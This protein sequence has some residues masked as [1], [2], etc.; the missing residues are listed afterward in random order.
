MSQ[1]N[2][3]THTFQKVLT[4]EQSKY[5]YTVNG[6]YVPNAKKKTKKFYSIASKSILKKECSGK[7]KKKKTFHMK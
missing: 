2:L 6:I 4:N 3:L 7:K 1:Y 5:C